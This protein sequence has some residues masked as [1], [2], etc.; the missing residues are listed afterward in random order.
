MN[1]DPA[2]RCQA[3]WPG[4]RGPA[5]WVC[6]G[7]GCSS[8][9]RP[10]PGR[11]RCSRPRS[12]RRF[13]GMPCARP[14]RRRI[15]CAPL[16]QQS[17]GALRIRDP[18]LTSARNESAAGRNGLRDDNQT[19]SF[20]AQCADDLPDLLCADRPSTTASR[21]R[22]RI[23]HK[24]A[25]SG[26]NSNPSWPATARANRPLV[27]HRPTTPERGVPVHRR[28]NGHRRAAA[29]AIPAD[30][31]RYPAGIFASDHLAEAREGELLHRRREDLR[32]HPATAHLLRHGS[33]GPRASKAIEDEI[34]RVGA[35]MDDALQQPL[36]LRRCEH[37]H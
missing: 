10:G 35:D 31:L 24:G 21:I 1:S 34:T 6:A 2:P 25:A 18:G 16:G 17:R 11:N 8:P 30:S 14:M 3:P 19:R 29:A 36:R 23:P 32:R 5:G 9:A 7:R 13:F 15:R 12:F 27:A 20:L 37:S 22:P 28:P 26:W 33:R 4:H